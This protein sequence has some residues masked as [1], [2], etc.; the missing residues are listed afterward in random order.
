MPE[1]ATSADSHWLADRFSTRFALPA[2]SL[3]H[4]EVLR[5]LRQRSRVIGA[6]ATPILI[7]VFLG[8]GMGRSF[9]VPDAGGQ[10]MADGQPMA[11][12]QAMADGPA[13]AGGQAGYLHYAFSGTMALI[14]LFTSI[15]ASISIIEDRN[16]GFLQAVLVSPAWR[17]SIAVGKVLGAGVLAFGQAA[18][19][20]ALAPLAGVTLTVGGV[21][22][23][24]GVLMLVAL[25]MSGLGFVTA[26]RTSSIQGYHSIMNLLLFPMWLL[27]GALF[28]LGG[29]S[30][31]IKVIMLANPLTYGVAALR[32]TLAGDGR[33]GSAG[34][35]ADAAMPSWT[36]SLV[37]TTLFAIVMIVA[38]TWTAAR[39]A[40]TAAG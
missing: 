11:G 3:A 10:P 33:A 1:P 23:T 24:L 39:P 35:T 40:R 34:P 2:V 38:A 22:Q 6:L 19:F 13:M 8:S 36:L 29:A 17:S 12:G 7:W 28:P 4:R 31:W 37:V 15:F 30:V 25:G 18:L 26:F 21:L 9:S 14:V 16:E 5:F 27:S 32:H 20:I